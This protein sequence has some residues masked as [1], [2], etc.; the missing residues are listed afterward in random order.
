MYAEDQIVVDAGY[1]GYAQPGRPFPATVQ[2]SVDEL[3]TG[4]L[5]IVD[6][7]GVGVGTTRHL[8]IAGG[9]TRDLEVVID[10][11]PWDIPNLRAELVAD[12]GG[13]V[14]ARANARL[15]VPGDADLIG[16]FPGAVEGRTLP[17]T[18]SL[19]VDAGEAR[20]FELS[21][22]VLSLGIGAIEPLDVIAVDGS[23]LRA[24]DP[25]E[26]DVLMTWLNEGGRLL[27]D[28]Q[29][30]SAVPGIPEAWQPDGAWPR[31]AGGGEVVM[32][33]G[34][35]GRSEWDKILEPAPTRSRYED[36]AFA[37]VAGFFGGEPLSWSLGRDAGFDL[38]GVRWM[39]V[40]VGAYVVVVGPLTWLVLRAI[41]RPGLAWV[42]I[43]AVSLLFTGGL[44]MLGSSVR[45]GVDAA[46]GTIIQVASSG[47]MASSFELVNS[48][49][50][51][52]VSMRI[53]DGWTPTGPVNEQL[54]GSLD[55]TTGDGSVTEV[56]TR[57]DAGAFMVLG[58][59]GP[60]PVVDG[61]VEVVADSDT[62][63]S[64]TGSVTNHLDVDLV[65][66]AV[67]ADQAAVN[68][69]DIDA[70]ATVD[71]ELDSAPVD[72][73][74]GEPVEFKVWREAISPD[75]TGDFGQPFEPGPI[76]LGL[77]SEWQ[78]RG[79]SNARQ[80]GSVV[81]AGWTDEMPSPLDATIER[82]R[83]LVVT[84]SAIG[85]G[86]DG[87]VTDVASARRIVRGPQ[88]VGN[89]FRNFEMWGGGA[90]MAFSLPEAAAGS[91]D[92]VLS[93]P[94]AQQRAELLVDDEWRQIDIAAQQRGVFELP[95]GAI[96][97]RGRVYVKVLL[98]FD[99][100]LTWRDLSVRTA[101]DRDEVAPMSFVIQDGD[102]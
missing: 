24:L 52:E 19:T 61:A 55:M 49:S 28:E 93:L 62:P 71:F 70:G 68:V 91:D 47:S 36:Q 57:L 100:G 63:G 43:P 46:H 2:V 38:P 25:A 87:A 92:L 96:D 82:G 35:A 31:P 60:L 30:G 102:A 94:R 21:A 73:N 97:E 41:R 5:R 6:Q 67:F 37:D 84:R 13:E 95:D 11:G 48:R 23:D 58:A 44:W 3:F 78:F 39:L 80:V 72:P 20:L 66:V 56:T 50:G 88:D 79:S 32:T 34:A 27:V 53:P 8:E 40:I 18:S 4:D 26:M 89:E 85:T 51:G 69:G 98:S 101:V 10:A 54:F 99:Q 77:W 29:P 1:G 12:D 7:N 76:N 16:V 59:S 64:V 14:I 83:T 81:V 75:W 74:R 45:D 15:K 65:G 22:D 17:E 9:T 33:D 42:M 90:V 86:D